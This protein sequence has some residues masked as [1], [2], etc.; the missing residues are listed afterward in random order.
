VSSAGKRAGIRPGTRSGLWAHFAHAI[1]QL[2]PSL[3][4]IENVRGLL[5][6][7]AHSDV[8]PCPWCLGD[9]TDGAL[10]ALGAVLGDL[11]DLGYDASWYGLRAADV[12]APH[13]RFR[14]FAVATPRHADAVG[15]VRHAGVERAQPT[16]GQPASHAGADALLPTPAGYDGDRG[17]PQHPDKR[18]A[19]GH[20][21]TLQDVATSLLPTPRAGDGEKGGPNQRGSSGDLTGSVLHG[22]WGQYAAAIA[23]WEHITRPAPPPTELGPK[24][25]PR[26]SAAFSEWLMGVP[27]GWITD[28]PG[29]TRNEA[30]RMAGNGVVPQQAAAALRFL[31]NVGEVAA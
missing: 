26:L 19:G 3:V 11:A 13:G 24:G 12:G 18:K 30:L 2:Q 4:V 5:S 8:E 20:S 17:G 29:V 25:N 22:Q 1:S 6:A 9:D 21:V 7:T 23:R 14:V 15:A 28:V 27:A 10:R 16:P 31:L